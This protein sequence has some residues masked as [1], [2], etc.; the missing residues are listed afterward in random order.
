MLAIKEIDRSD[1]HQV[2]E[3]KAKIDPWAD[4]AAQIGV[5]VAIIVDPAERIGLEQQRMAA[6]TK[7]HLTIDHQLAERAEPAILGEGEGL[8]ADKTRSRREIGIAVIKRPQADKA[9]NARRGAGRSHMRG[10]SCRLRALRLGERAGLQIGK[11]S[12][13]TGIIADPQKHG[14]PCQPRRVIGRIDQQ[15]ALQG[16][17]SALKI[18]GGKLC[19][20]KGKV[21]RHTVRIGQDRLVGGLLV[22][23]LRMSPI[24][25][26]QKG[27]REAQADQRHKTTTPN[28]GWTSDLASDRESVFHHRER[29][30]PWIG[31]ALS[32]WNF[33]L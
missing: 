25:D 20:Q 6:P 18:S 31:R 33:Y 19:V 17:G 28:R 32:A 10:K 27:E 13:R 26:A 12:G 16:G 29:S 7:R 23:A 3:G 24:A 15:H 4:G 14:G 9:R 11:I 2:K 21:G 1:R 22:R 5:A 30:A 8:I